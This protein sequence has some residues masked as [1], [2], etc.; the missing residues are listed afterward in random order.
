MKTILLSLIVV[1]FSCN[2]KENNVNDI[3]KQVPLKIDVKEQ[4]LKLFNKE[5]SEIELKE[6]GRIYDPKILVGDLNGDGLNDAVVWYSLQPSDGGNY[7]ISEGLCV[8]VSSHNSVLKSAVYKIDDLFTLESIIECKIKIFV[9]KYAKD[10]LPN[11]P[12]IKV[13]KYLILRQN[14]L[15]ELK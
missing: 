3:K 5:S 2:K 9:Y 14:K 8:Y 1:F 7:H 4:A 13:S 11:N 15:E 6:G 10:D 12:S